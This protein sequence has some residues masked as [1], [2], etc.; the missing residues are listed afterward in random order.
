MLAWFGAD[1]LKVERLGPLKGI[2]VIDF[3]GE[4]LTAFERVVAPFEGI[5]I[6]RSMD[7]GELI[8]AGSPTNNTALAPSRVAGGANGLFEVAA[9][10]TLR[11]FVDVSQAY[12]P[13][14]TAG[15]PVKVVARP[16]RPAGDR[17]RHTHRERARSGYPDTAH[18]SRGSPSARSNEWRERDGRRAASAHIA[19][20]C[21][22]SLQ[23]F[24]MASTCQRTSVFGFRAGTLTTALSIQA[25]ER[26]EKF[27]VTT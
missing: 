17:H 16:A 23:N 25:V 1:V 26:S 3:T 2:K 12:A 14:M 13:N 21:R 5:V 15:L 8:T 19:E 10:D 7:V 20:A 9:I 18:P 27:F 22:V 4:E 24:V 11:V 6:Q